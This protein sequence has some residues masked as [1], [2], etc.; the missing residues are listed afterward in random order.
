MSAEDGTYT[1]DEIY[2]AIKRLF[3]E[4]DWTWKRL[5]ATGRRFYAQGYYRALAQVFGDFC[6]QRD[7]DEEFGEMD[8]SVDPDTG[9]I[10][11]H[12]DDDGLPLDWP[13]FAR[14]QAGGAE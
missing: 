3:V 4:D 2:R 6:V 9:N 8:F 10:W 13:P 12:I 5:G 7:Y 11:H 1:R 14:R